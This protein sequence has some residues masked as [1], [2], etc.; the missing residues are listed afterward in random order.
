MF[1]FYNSWKHVII[2]LFRRQL[3]RM[4]DSELHVNGRPL[5]KKARKLLE[6]LILLALVT[7]AFLISYNFILN[8]LGS[9]GAYRKA[10]LSSEISANMNY[11]NV[12]TIYGNNYFSDS[13][14][15]KNTEILS[16]LQYQEE[17][18]SYNLDAAGDDANHKSLGNISG[19]GSIPINGIHR[20]ELDLAI[21]YYEYFKLLFD[22]YPDIAWLYYTSNHGFVSMYPST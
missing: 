1:G 4:S 2:A 3:Y 6:Y 8:D 21:D 9:A 7:A 16:L 14:L 17:S 20:K 18:D 15:E 12:L 5:M 19:S 22:K 11:I 10:K 13:Q